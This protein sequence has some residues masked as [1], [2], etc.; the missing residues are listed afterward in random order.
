MKEAIFVQGIYTKLSLLLSY[1]Y[2]LNRMSLC[3]SI[4]THRPTYFMPTVLSFIIYYSIQKR[5]L[6]HNENIL[7]LLFLDNLCI[8]K[9]S[10]NK[11]PVYIILLKIIGICNRNLVF[12]QNVL[13]CHMTSNEFL[14]STWRNI[15]RQ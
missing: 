11:V 15:C 12:S 10:C 14:V 4:Y 8:F 13:L 1:T 5:K 6:L 2:V 9:I 7:S 3:N